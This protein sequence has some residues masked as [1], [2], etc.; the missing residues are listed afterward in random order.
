[1][2]TN[3]TVITVEAM[4]DAPLQKVWDCWTKPEHIIHWNFA[5]GDWHAPAAENDL[6]PGG[7]FVFRMEAKD[8]SMGFDFSGIYD[9]VKLNE[10]IECSLGDGRK[11][12][13]EFVAG[14]NTTKVSE[15]FDA[16]NENPVELQRAGWQAILDNFKKYT[17][18]SY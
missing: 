7:K 1:M 10:T 11:M 3:I 17:E 4:I 12:K 5:S 9:A 13:V 2:E 15:S 8:G 14:D 18:E 16:E 6:R